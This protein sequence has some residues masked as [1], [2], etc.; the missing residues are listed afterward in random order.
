MWQ[1]ASTAVCVAPGGQ[2]LHKGHKMVRYRY[3][4]HTYLSTP[5]HY[6]PTLPT[7]LST[8][9]LPKQTQPTQFPIYRG[10]DKPDQEGN[11]LQRQTILCFIYRIYIHNWRNICAFVCVYVYIYN[12]NSIKRNILTMKQNTSGIRSA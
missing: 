4:C 12:K 11:K 10:A 7:N 5:T 3:Y 2:D 1:I 6:P 8:N 9:T